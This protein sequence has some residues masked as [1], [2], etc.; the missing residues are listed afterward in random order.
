MKKLLL[1]AVCLIV[2]SSFAS[3]K[4]IFGNS[5]EVDDVPDG[6][7][8]VKYPTTLNGAEG[9]GA[10]IKSAD[11]GGGADGTMYGIEP[12]NGGMQASDPTDGWMYSIYPDGGELIDTAGYYPVGVGG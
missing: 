11:V 2:L 7:A 8:P 6:G 4:D 1:I 3:A 10:P 5:I 9:S 12:G